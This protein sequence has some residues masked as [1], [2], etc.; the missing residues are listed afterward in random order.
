MEQEAELYV[1]D[2]VAYREH[3]NKIEGLK[4][5]HAVDMAQ[6]DG[7]IRVESF[8]VW[9]QIGDAISGAFSTAI[10]GVILGTQSLTQAMRNMAQNVLL[11]LLDMGVRW[12]AQQIINAAIGKAIDKQAKASEINNAAA[13]AAANAFA[14]IA[15]IPIVGPFLAP[16]A[17]A[18]AASPTEA[19]QGALVAAAGGFDVPA[20]LNPMTQL[21]PK[22]MVLPAELA[23]GV[24]DT[25]AGG[26]GGGDVH[27][28]VHAMDTKGVREYLLNNS[29]VLAP[30]LRD[31]VRRHA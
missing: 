29:H 9:H 19:W 11:A 26:G 1:D 10:K 6:I 31:L 14:S 21:H 18:V 22:E 28:H 24:R 23:E 12:V 5:Q 16:E 20:G 17:A 15:A 27:L 7:Q 4:Q 3:L 2:Q 8:R 30:A 13:L 25:I